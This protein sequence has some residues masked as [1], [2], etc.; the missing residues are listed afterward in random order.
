MTEAIDQL[1]TIL[2]TNW[3]TANYD[4]RGY[5]SITNFIRKIIDSPK[6]G[7]QVA[8]N[9]YIFIYHVLEDF[10]RPTLSQKPKDTYV[11]L[12]IGMRTNTSARLDSIKNEVFRVLDSQIISPGGGWGRMTYGNIVERSDKSKHLHWK[13]FEVKFYKL[14]TT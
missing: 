13:V 11:T 9:D 6:M 3:L 5:S 14:G 1:I 12:S 2:R 8:N 7:I 10:D 4:P